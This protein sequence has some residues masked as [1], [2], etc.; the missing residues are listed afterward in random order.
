MSAISSHCVAQTLDHVSVFRFCFAACWSYAFQFNVIIFNSEI[1]WFCP[2]KKKRRRKSACHCPD[3]RQQLSDS[4]YHIGSYIALSMSRPV[5]TI[6]QLNT[7]PHSLH[8]GTQTM[9][10]RW[11]HKFLINIIS[12]QTVNCA[13][14]LCK[15]LKVKRR[16]GTNNQMDIPCA[17]AKRNRQRPFECKPAWW[18]CAKSRSL[19]LYIKIDAVCCLFCEAIVGQWGPDNLHTNFHHW[20]IIGNGNTEK[21]V[22]IF[23]RWK[24]EN[25]HIHSFLLVNSAVV[26][27]DV[28]I[29]FFY[30][31]LYAHIRQQLGAYNWLCVTISIRADV[32]MAFSHSDW[33]ILIDAAS[34]LWW[35]LLLRWQLKIIHSRFT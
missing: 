16:N 9:P 26:V 4:I 31:S 20:P 32:W 17:C 13:I 3:N 34:E 22:I 35:T 21:F 24:C 2:E 18:K 23:D 6:M 25:A 11:E 28:I 12:M 33:C 14:V 30:F 15:R 27:V 1:V 5:T 19:L 10:T 7:I 29:F 8:S